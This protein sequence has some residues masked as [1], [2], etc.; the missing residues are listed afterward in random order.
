[1][2]SPTQPARDG[3]SKMRLRSGFVPNVLALGVRSNLNESTTIKAQ[4]S[5]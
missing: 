2:G 5:V 1:M 4:M 3:V